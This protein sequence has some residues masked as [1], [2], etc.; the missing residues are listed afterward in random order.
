MKKYL[1]PNNGNFYKANLHC[2]STISDGVMTPEEL[3]DKYK[4]KGYSIVAYTDHNIMISHPYLADKNF[5]P[6]NGY[7]I[8]VN[9]PIRP[10][11]RTCHICLIALEPDNLKQICWHRTDY[12][13]ENQQKYIEKIQFYEEEP[14]F[15]REYT[16][17]CINEIMKQG[18][19]R[20]FFVTYNHPTWSCETYAEYSQ[21]EHMHAME[22]TNYACRLEGH[23]EYNARVYDDMIRLGKNIYC[24]GTDD[25][26]SKE[27]V[28]G[29]WTM[30]KANKLEY[31]TITKALEEGHFY[32]SQGP[33]IHELWI[34]DNQICIRTSDVK[35]ILFN[36]GTRRPKRVG[37]KAG[38]T[39]SFAAVE[40]ASNIL[41]IRVTVIDYEGR[42]ANTNTYFI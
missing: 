21:Y 41:W 31:R 1:L 33:E 9:D 30:I 28:G 25:T 10:G 42:K 36:F 24:I 16:P 29:A 23:E 6:L 14:D 35:E 40:I 7:E 3:K 12:Y 4:E 39:I 8:N 11:V 13:K 5:L 34:E 19:E 15:V 18:R 27:S 22:I 2:H 32:S 26:H 38:E 20:G 37:A 17:D